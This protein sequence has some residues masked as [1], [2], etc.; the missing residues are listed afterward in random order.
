MKSFGLLLLSFAF[1]IS[2]FAQQKA[3]PIPADQYHEL[4]TVDG[5][6]PRLADSMRDLVV[7]GATVNRKTSDWNLRKDYQTNV[8]TLETYV[9]DD[10]TLILGF[11]LNTNTC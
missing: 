5:N 9:T 11:T 6:G 3:V 2:S 4:S 7:L 1:S 10:V 8:E